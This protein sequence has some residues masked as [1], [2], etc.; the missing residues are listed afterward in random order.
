MQE[1]NIP[2]SVTLIDELQQDQPILLAAGHLS[3]LFYSLLRDE[4]LEEVLQ[5]FIVPAHRDP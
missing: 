2:S 4:E 5:E 3:H 1:D